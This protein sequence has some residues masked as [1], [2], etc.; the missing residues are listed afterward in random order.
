MIHD[1]KTH[2][3]EQAL[4]G[5]AFWGSLMT[6]LLGQRQDGERSGLYNRRKIFVRQ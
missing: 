6:P 3:F 1:E 5:S 4:L 2:N